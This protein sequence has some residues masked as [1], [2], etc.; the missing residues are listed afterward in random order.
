MYYILTG[1]ESISSPNNVC[2]RHFLSQ[3]SNY[4]ELQFTS[5]I[6]VSVQ[7]G[8]TQ[9]TCLNITYSLNILRKWNCECCH[10]LY[11]YFIQ[12]L[13]YIIG[14]DNKEKDNENLPVFKD[15]LETWQL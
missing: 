7:F 2:Y 11:S 5:R 10:M 4:F 6:S 13:A 8:D 15:N 12:K 1:R 3:S 9:Q 14:I